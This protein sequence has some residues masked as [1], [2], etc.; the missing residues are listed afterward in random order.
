MSIKFNYIYLQ[1]FRVD[2][3]EYKRSNKIVCIRLYQPKERR[4]SQCA[5]AKSMAAPLLPQRSP[6]R[7]LTPWQDPVAARP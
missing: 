5:L 7:I 6:P 3:E 4:D 2:E 1:D